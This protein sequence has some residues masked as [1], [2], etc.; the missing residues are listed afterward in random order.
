MIFIDFQGAFVMEDFRKIED[1]LFYAKYC[2]KKVG[3]PE[4]IWSLIKNNRILLTSYF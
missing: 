3:N 4:E 1:I 2:D